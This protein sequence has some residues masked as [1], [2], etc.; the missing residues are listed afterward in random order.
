[1]FLRHLTLAAA[2]SV[3][4]ACGPDDTS[5]E[6][7]ETASSQSAPLVGESVE[8]FMYTHCGVESL[9]LDGRWWQAVEPVYGVDGPGSPPEGW[10]DPYEKGELTLHSD[11]HVTFETED[12]QIAF[13][14]APDNRPRRTCR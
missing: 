1:M 4:A 2:L 9:R 3:V 8:F 7:G 14:P 5:L 10:G 12:T 13:V 11:Q 6:T